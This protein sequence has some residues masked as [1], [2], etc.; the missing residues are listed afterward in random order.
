MALP[1]NTASALAI[2]SRF[3]YPDNLVTGP[4]EDWEDG[5]VDIQDATQ[6]LMGYRW[7]CWVDGINVKAQRDGAAEVTLFSAAGISSISLAFD[8]AMRPHVAY[9]IAGQMYLRW[10]DSVAVAYVTTNFGMARNPRLA[11][12]DKR[13]EQLNTNDVILA[14]IRD[15]SLFYRQQRDR[16]A[17]ERLLR[18]GLPDYTILRNIGMGDNL[19]MHFELV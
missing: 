12:D 19:R 18:P 3:L 4:M 17:V 7:R 10:Y 2:A 5:G 13:P 8:Q 6:G 14:Y 9:T 15:N 1:G 16:F 11:L